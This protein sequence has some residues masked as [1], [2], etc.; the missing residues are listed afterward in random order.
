MRS[1]RPVLMLVAASLLAGCGAGGLLS[2]TTN[3]L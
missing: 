3:Y 2:F 1:V